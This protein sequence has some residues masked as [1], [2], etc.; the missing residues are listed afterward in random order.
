MTKLKIKQRVQVFRATGF[1]VIFG[2]AYFF[3]L[4]AVKAFAQKVSRWLMSPVPS[5]WAR[6]SHC[7]DHGGRAHSSRPV[8]AFNRWHLNSLAKRDDGDG[9]D[10]WH[11]ISPVEFVKWKL[12]LR[13]EGRYQDNLL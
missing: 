10:D 9:P 3:P 12:E 6:V 13:R 11:Y 5:C 2:Q 4:A 1:I 8:F 7:C